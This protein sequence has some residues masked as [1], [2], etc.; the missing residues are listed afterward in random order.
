MSANESRN[1]GKPRHFIQ[2]IIEADLA[3]GKHPRIHTRFP[4]EPN[5]Y[6][7]IGHAKA[8]CVNFGLAEQYGGLCNLRFDDT[9]PEKEEA[10]YEKAIAEDVRWLGFHWD[11]RLF[12][13]SDYFDRLYAF[14]VELIRKGLAYVCELSPEQMRAQRGTLTE[15]GQNSP[16]RDR[17]VEENLR[18]FEAMK[19]GEF[20]EGKAVL[21]AR[22]DMTSPNLNLRDPVIYRVRHTPHHATGDRWC[23]YPMYD[24]THCISDA[25]EGIT[26]SLCTLEFEDH[27]PLYDWFLDHVSVPCHPQ[28]IEF[29][30]LELDYVVTSKRKLNQLVQEGI[31]D[32]W[33]DPRMPTLS[34]LRRRGL[35]PEAIRDFIDRVG[36]T[37]KPATIE[38]GL[39]ETC[40]RDWLGPRAPR[41][42]AVLDPI[43]VVITNYPE[44]QE[45]TLHAPLHSQNPDMGSRPLPF[46]REIYIE[47]DDF[48]EDPPKKYFRLKPGGAVRLRYAYLIDFQQVVRDDEGNIVEIH[49]TYDP[50]T[51]SGQDTSGRKVKGTIHWV[52]ARQ[53]IPARV[54]LIDRL[55][56]VPDPDRRERPFTDFINP[57]A[58]VEC[59]QARLEPALADIDPGQAMQ[60]ERLGYF[61]PDSRDHR[62]ERPVF[63]R[64]MTLRDTWAK[65]NH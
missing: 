50:Q 7:H 2:Q 14:A 20:E 58:M 30:R 63:N 24:Y 12:H 44:G 56:T 54:R 8:I 23:I 11:D 27:R 29:A 65:K 64:I 60:F 43:K 57:Q 40:V 59:D 28:Q 47:R 48:M 46:G 22:I 35:P 34:G 18:L 55:F 26:H 42:M 9:N 10:A 45:E 31:V 5:G 3:S 17:S 53:A 36:V 15:P 52:A 37:K 61:T 39:L 32:G 4:P 6:L 25:L 19:N 49:C 33:D 38:L 62:P 21:R 16:Y 13:A 1:G 51:R 41:Y